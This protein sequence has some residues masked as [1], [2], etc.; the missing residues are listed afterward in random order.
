MDEKLIEFK[1]KLENRTEQE[2]EEQK[3][4]LQEHLNRLE[5]EYN[6]REEEKKVNLLQIGGEKAVKLYEQYDTDYYETIKDALLSGITID[7]LIE[8]FNTYEDEKI[9]YMFDLKEFIEFMINYRHL[10]YNIGIDLDS[11]EG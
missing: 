10:K 4:Q 8:L 3:K 7:K 9:K 11:I 6:K 1:R 5:K 2:R